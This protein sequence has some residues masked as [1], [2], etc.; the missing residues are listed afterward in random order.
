MLPKVGVAFRCSPGT[1]GLIADVT[2]YIVRNPKCKFVIVDTLGKV[3]AKQKS[4]QDVFRSDYSD[5]SDIQQ[6]AQAAG[7]AILLLHH[8]TKHVSCEGDIAEVS[9]SFGVS[10][11][12][13]NVR[14]LTREKKRTGVDKGALF[15]MGRD[16]RD[17]KYAMEFEDG[18]WRCKG[19]AGIQEIT[20]AKQEI[21]KCF[22]S[23]Q[24]RPLGPS[25]VKELMGSSKKKQTIAEHI[26]RL[27]DD[28]Y[29]EASTLK[30]K[31]QVTPPNTNNSQGGISV[32]LP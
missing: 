21:L 26:S 22:L 13:D 3:R 10:G 7:V 4:N 16:V 24:P 25:E 28:G 14:I 30:G 23:E 17:S 15:V 2:K 5:L 18:I 32:T 1:G 9:G 6:L 31:Y 20:E 8:T 19:P 12:A 27:C 29:L 11:G